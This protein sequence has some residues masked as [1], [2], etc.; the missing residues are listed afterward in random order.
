MLDILYFQPMAKSPALLCTYTFKTHR[1]K[2]DGRVAKAPSRGM[3][4]AI[5][6]RAR[7]RK[8]RR[9]RIGAGGRVKTGAIVT[10]F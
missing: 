5:P 9:F 3:A 7:C 10:H 6:S 1:D 2:R 8:R 4:R